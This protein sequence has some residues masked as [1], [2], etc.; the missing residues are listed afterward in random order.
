MMRR[1]A[2]S[3]GAMAWPPGQTRT[4]E[5]PLHFAAQRPVVDQL[6][7]RHRLGTRFLEDVMRCM[8]DAGLDLERELAHR[9]PTGHTVLMAAVS[10]GDRDVVSRLLQV[11]RLRLANQSIHMH[12][13]A[14][15]ALQTM[16][17]FTAAKKQQALRVLNTVLVHFTQVRWR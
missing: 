13:S 14:L 2:P 9:R 12:L 6:G 11:S 8:Q 15:R 10:G 16:D 4:Q 1:H 3:L 5:S 7:R 17:T